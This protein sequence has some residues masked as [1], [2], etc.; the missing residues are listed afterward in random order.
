MTTRTFTTLSDEAYLDRGIA[1]YESFYRLMTARSRQGY[2]QPSFK[3]YYLCLDEKTFSVL[4]GIN[5]ERLVPLF[6]EDEFRDN[7]DFETLVK[8][9]KAVPLGMSH[10]HFALGS[11]F[12]H[13]I[14]EKVFP[15]Y[16]LYVDADIIFYY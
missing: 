8:H 9:N 6:I 14:M 1:L 3:L 10:F 11:F 2:L 7:K 15:E 4:K 5:D 16:I 13:H 12:T